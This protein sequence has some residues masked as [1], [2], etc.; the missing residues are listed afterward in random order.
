MNE[1]PTTTGSD[2]EY[3]GWGPRCGAWLVDGLLTWIP[4]SVVASVLGAIVGDP[5]AR[6]DP[7]D[8]LVSASVVLLRI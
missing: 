4:L 8:E 1:T 2:V 7:T 3:A 5:N 6:G